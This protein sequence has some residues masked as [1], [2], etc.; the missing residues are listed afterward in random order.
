MKDWENDYAA[1]LIYQDLADCSLGVYPVA[2][3]LEKPKKVKNA[4]K[5]EDENVINVNVL[6][7]VSMFLFLF[8][9]LVTTV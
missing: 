7:K 8:I 3:E 6:K 4:A 1:S 9:T 2:A 5:L